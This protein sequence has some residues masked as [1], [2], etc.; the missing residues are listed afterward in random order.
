MNH[1]NIACGQNIQSLNITVGGTLT[2]TT[3]HFRAE[4]FG[5]I[6]KQNVGSMF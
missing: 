6:N 4:G 3:E 5:D 1:I 2:V